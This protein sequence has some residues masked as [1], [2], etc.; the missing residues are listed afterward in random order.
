MKIEEVGGLWREVNSKAVQK[1]EEWEWKKIIQIILDSD[2][3][4][5]KYVFT[6][7][8]KMQFHMSA[9][10]ENT[11]HM[12]MKNYKAHNKHNFIIRGRCVGQ[13][14]WRRHKM[15][16][17]RLFWILQFH[18]L[19]FVWNCHV[20]GIFLVFFL[21]AIWLFVPSL[22]HPICNKKLILYRDQKGFWWAYI[23][24]NQGQESCI[25]Q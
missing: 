15:D 16:L 14:T 24:K 7:V 9:W 19:C 3:D 5:V 6:S 18:I 25:T 17:I 1:L 22:F 4:E 12:F 21:W 13:T 10:L 20:F 8:V 23:C 11:K 2:S